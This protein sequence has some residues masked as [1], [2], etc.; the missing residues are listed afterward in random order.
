MRHRGFIITLA[1]FTWMRVLLSLRLG[2]GVDEAHYALYGTRLDWSYFDHPPL[3]GW[4]HA[5]FQRVFGVSEFSTRI[6]ALVI[7]VIASTTSYLWIYRLSSS[8]R[9]AYYSN[10]AL[11]SSFLFNVLAFSLLPENF[12]I[13][14]ALPLIFLLVRID[15]DPR[16][17]GNWILLGSILGVSGLAKYTAIVFAVAVTIFWLVQKSWN[18]FF[19]LRILLVALIAAVL[20]TPVFY[21]N[22]QND[23]LSFKYQ[24]NHVVS[25]SGFSLKPFLL[26]RGREWIGHGPLL[27]PWAFLG[28]FWGLR[29]RERTIRAAVVVGGIVFLFF[30][31]SSLKTATLPHWSAVFFYLFIPLGTAMA[32]TRS[33]PIQR[34]LKACVMTSAIL[35]VIGG[36]I[37]MGQFVSFPDFKSP[38]FDVIGFK[39]A[40]A[41]AGVRLRAG[42]RAESVPR[43]A[44]PHW[45]LM[46]RFTF[47]SRQD[48]R[49]VDSAKTQFSFWGG[50]P[51]LGEDLL[52]VSDHF[53][54]CDVSQKLKCG[55]VEPTVPFEIKMRN[56][57]INRFEMTWCR[58]YQGL[59]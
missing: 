41:E 26:S 20:V 19:S 1:V 51:A 28:F 52:V 58:D 47:Y 18:V 37:V 13:L 17:I 11:Q 35:T 31:Y 24:F 54:P 34:L 4:V 50:Q 25:E 33:S 3:V 55:R 14:F 59:R 36:V 29:S 27:V 30:A 57:L 21:W 8:I 32:L 6:P 45:V 56:H 23:F 44:V 43:I 48:V 39:E 15:R 42:A 5:L 49:L 53:Y 12:L 38:F 9:I 7:S 10:L 2:L 46:S 22:F 40:A 16:K